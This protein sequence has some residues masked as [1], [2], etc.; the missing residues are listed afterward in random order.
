M[1]A[2]FWLLILAA[3][4]VG[5]ALAAR[6]NEGYVLLV[7]PPWRAEL[8]LNLF[9]LALIAG[10][11]VIYLLARAVNH[12]LVLP[13][14]VAEFRQRRQREKAALA[15]RDAW[16]LLQEGRYGQAMRC[17]EKVRPESATSGMLALAG[18]RAAH[19]MR[20]AERSAQWA[21]RVRE[22]DA[23][24]LQ[25]ARL[26]TEAEFALEDRRFEDARDA[27]QQLASRQ[28][29]HIAALRLS[30]RAEQGLGNWREVARLVRQLEKHQ[31]LTPEL[32]APIHSRAVREALRS[33]REDPSGLMRYW[34]ELDDGDRAE[35]SLALETARA[36]AAAGDCREAQ[37]VIEDALDESWDASLVLAY[38]ECGQAGEPAGDVLGRIAQAEKWLERAPRDG[39]LLL[40]LGRLCRQQQ[41]WGK[42]RSY[43]EAALAIAPSRAAHVELAQ[44]LDQ[45]EESAL[46]VRHYR[47]AA[48][49]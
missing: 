9:L 13:R 10:F 49:L 1:R 18:W 41:L 33:L 29:R 27:L 40:T 20:D 15:L 30:V 25:A 8:S 36:L 7:L 22:H 3:L 43:L 32:A 46:A 12:I 37:R 5:L 17:A 16:R 19:A 39:A 26:M 42:A 23:V 47:A 31:A 6:Y 45:L 48:V 11:F 14:A 44:L 4:A 28:G 2:L 21:M 24:G 34:R 35:P 38:G